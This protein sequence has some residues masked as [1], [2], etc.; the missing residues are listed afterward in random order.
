[1]SLLIKLM[2]STLPLSARLSKQMARVFY[3]CRQSIKLMARLFYLGQSIKLMA[4]L[5]YLCQSI[6][7]M[8]VLVEYLLLLPRP[9]V[10]Q[11]LHPLVPRTNQ[12]CYI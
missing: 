2:T 7:L 4:R 12:N 9:L 3:L 6:K 8:A 1:M 5:F 11:P 10:A